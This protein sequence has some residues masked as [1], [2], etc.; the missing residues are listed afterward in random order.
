M[1]HQIILAF[2]L[3]ACVSGCETR[4]NAPEGTSDQAT[5]E[6]SRAPART[7]GRTLSEQAPLTLDECK[8]LHSSEARNA[9]DSLRAACETSKDLPGAFSGPECVRMARYEACLKVFTSDQL[10]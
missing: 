10:Q 3:M 2:A 8:G 7:Q 4:T 6:P 5:P 1:K 9:M